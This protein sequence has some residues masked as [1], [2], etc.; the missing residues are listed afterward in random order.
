MEGAL[1]LF[2]ALPLPEA[3]RSELGR[4]QQGQAGPG[5]WSRPEGLHLTLAFLGLR[6]PEGLGRLAGAG[7]AVAARHRALR[8]RTAGLGGFPG[9]DRAR[10]LWLGVAPEPALEALA[11]DLRAV[12]AEA[13]EPFD[14]KA[15]RPHITLARFRRPRPVAAAPAPPPA[16][17]EV[18]ELVL[19]E[20]RPQGWYVPFRSWCLGG[21][22]AG[23]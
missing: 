10:V 12:L 8:L 16:A 19:F 23:V 14:A 18:P 3:L 7:A 11:E 1:R 4:W 22:P 5:G 9:E 17:F 6:P 21:H 2:F 15:F 13:G 20:S